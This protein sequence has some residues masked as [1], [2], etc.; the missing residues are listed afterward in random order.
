[1]QNHHKPYKDILNHARQSQI[2]QGTL[3]SCKTISNYTFNT[4]S[5]HARP[6]HIMHRNIRP[7]KTISNQ[8]IQYN[9]K[10][11]KTISNYTTPYHSM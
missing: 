1:M 4:I 2:M 6:F 9:L 5:D 11:C 10:S 3:K 7:Y 8:A